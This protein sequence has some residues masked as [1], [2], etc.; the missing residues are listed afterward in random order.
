LGHSIVGLFKHSGDADLAADYLR[1]E[2]VLRADELDVIGQAEWDRLTRPAMDAT[3]QWIAASLT[4]IGLD[5]SLG[6]E[7]PV[8]K[9]WGDKVWQGDTLVV[10]RTP[11]PEIAQEIAEAMH[12]TGAARIDLLPH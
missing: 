5:P 6:D 12:R 3:D 2:Y 11:D 7:D 9:R 1:E 4:G 10:A 8:G